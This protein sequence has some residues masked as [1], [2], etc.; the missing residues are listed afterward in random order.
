M[1]VR[2]QMSLQPQSSGDWYSELLKLSPTLAA[3]VKASQ[4]Q[5]A[6]TLMPDAPTPDARLEAITK[7]QQGLA[8]DFSKAMP[9]IE[10]ERSA[11]IGGDTSRGLNAEIQGLRGNAQSRGLLYSGIR[12]GAEMGAR[13]D[14]ALGAVQKRVDM[15]KGLE[16]TRANLEGAAVDSGLNLAGQATGSGAINAAGQRALDSQALARQQSTNDMY[17][18]IGQGLGSGLGSIGARLLGKK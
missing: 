17:S 4:A 16:D 12:G 3:R 14:A 9:A 7:R 1:A 18:Q 10:R 13:R 15:R 8:R 2:P 5:T 11:I 6:Q